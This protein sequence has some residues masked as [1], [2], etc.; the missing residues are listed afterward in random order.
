[1]AFPPSTAVGPWNISVGVT[2]VENRRQ[3]LSRQGLQCPQDPM[4]LDE[5]RY[6]TETSAAKNCRPVDM[7]R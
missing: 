3:Q 7:N 1:M 4:V 5:R 6:G 2:D